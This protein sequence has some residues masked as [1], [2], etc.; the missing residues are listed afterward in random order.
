MIL[1]LN[2]GSSSLKAE[3]FGEGLASVL[4]LSVREIGGAG[5]LRIGAETR[6]AAAPDHEAALAMVLK[7]LAEAGHP[8][9]RL[10]A[11]GHRVVHGGARR[12]AARVTPDL[13]EEIRAAIPLAPLHNPANLAGIEALGRLAPGL[14]QT[15]SFDTA[16]HASQ[17]DVATAYALPE[18]LRARGLRRYGFH[19]LS[20]ASIVARLDPLPERLLAFHLGNGASLCAIRGGQSVASSMGY[21]PL[22]GLVMGTRVGDIDAALVLR[23][24]EEEGIE[25]AG[26]ILM[27]QSGLRGLA[28]TSDMERL[29]ARDDAEARFAVALFCHAAISHAGAAIAAMGGVDALVFTGGIGEHAA[30]VREA[31]TAGLAFLGPLPAHVLPAEEERQ[32]ARDTARLLG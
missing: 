16:F 20:Y 10:T 18:P 7:A 28:G 4:A 26:D 21:S 31:I 30:P 24:A 2:A 11:A 1:V 32:I 29:L 25:A 14:P 27:R 13:V 15:A 17:S 19:G 23:L 22:S 6:P 12:Q 5:E 9:E 8:P 3:L